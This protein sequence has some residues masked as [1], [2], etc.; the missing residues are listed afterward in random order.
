MAS[1]RG[2]NGYLLQPSATLV[3]CDSSMRLLVHVDTQHDH[4]V[5]S[6]QCERDGRAG[7][8]THF[9]RGDATLLSSH[10]GRS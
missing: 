6:F 5:V 9:S 4:E 10:A 2:P 1:I 7:R 8:R 3:D